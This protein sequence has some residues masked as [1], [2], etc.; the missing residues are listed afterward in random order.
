MVLTNKCVLSSFDVDAPNTILLFQTVACVAL[1]TASHHMGLIHLERLNRDIVWLWWPVNVIFVGMIWSSFYSLKNLGVAMVT[2]LKNLTNILTIT[3][4]IY[5]YG[6]SYSVG[7]WLALALISLSAVCG[8]ATDLAFNPVGYGWQ[9][10]NCCFTAGYS[11][12]LRGVMDK[13][14]AVNGGK[15]LDEFGMVYYN[16]LLASPLVAAIALQQG[17]LPRF[18][19]SP[20]LHDP[21]FLLALFGSGLMGFMIS[22][23]SLWF[24]AETTAGTYSLVGSLNKIPVAIIGLVAFNTPT[25]PKNVGSILIG[26]LAGVAFVRAKQTSAKKGGRARAQAGKGAAGAKV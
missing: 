17:E 6:K 20:T 10:L 4:D 22:F 24:L 21:K 14:P 19:S 13:I 7:V 16:N 2:V 18:F 3:G 23:A 12:F 5:L 25:N 8:A 1:V 11:L 26:L 9:F 15:K